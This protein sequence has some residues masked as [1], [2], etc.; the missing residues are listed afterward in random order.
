MK[1]RIRLLTIVVIASVLVL[2]LRMGDIWHGLSAIEGGN[3]A[4]A[5][6]ARAG[7]VNPATG[8]DQS[9]S[10]DVSKNEKAGSAQGQAAAPVKLGPAPADT[11]P[12][13]EPAAASAAAAPSRATP[14]QPAAGGVAAAQPQA[15]PA[16][17][18]VVKG[19]V[20]NMNETEIELL[21]N[22][23]ARRAV[24]DARGHELELRE[25]VLKA[26]EQRLNERLKELDTI[27]TELEARLKV[28]EDFEAT[29][30]K[31]L[32]KVYETMKPKEAARIFEQL[33]TAVLVEFL[34]HMKEQK[35]APILA[36]MDPAKA[37]KITAELAARRQIQRP[38]S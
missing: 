9:P 1:R 32:V 37:Q 18:P 12:A 17:P 36:A 21:Q 7:G 30:L 27:K 14:A 4:A 16:Q 19:D 26:A 25:K 5:Q 3:G 35:M 28:Q 8:Q 13:A 29:R 15:A 2:P 20:T 33:D 34:E 11:K 10:A 31:S 38:K 22:L 23:A 6:S 24:L